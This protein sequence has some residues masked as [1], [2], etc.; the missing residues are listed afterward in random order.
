MGNSRNHGCGALIR[1]A[2]LPVWSGGGILYMANPTDASS[3][4]CQPFMVL[5]ILASVAAGLMVY[6]P[7]RMKTE[8]VRQE[9]AEVRQRVEQLRER[10][11]RLQER[12]AALK[13]GD[14]LAVRE[15]IRETLR[16][17]QAG[18]VTLDATL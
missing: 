4:F 14:P 10:N 8:A 13:A 3:R 6:L 1:P 11:L 18:D 5:L 9:L 7:S 16:K 15:A 2:V 12:I 17:G